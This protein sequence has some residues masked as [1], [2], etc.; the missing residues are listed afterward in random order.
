MR[1][2]DRKNLRGGV[3][4]GGQSFVSNLEMMDIFD[5]YC[6]TIS[7][8]TRNR[9]ISGIIDIQLYKDL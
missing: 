1:E 8:F 4:R 2:H 6:L 3:D 9:D 5:K 7:G